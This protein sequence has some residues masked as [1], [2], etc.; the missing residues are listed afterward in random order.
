MKK[1]LALLLAFAVMLGCAACGG[2][3]ESDKGQNAD[4]NTPEVKK[5]GVVIYNFD[6]NFMTLY[7]KELERYFE[8]LGTDERCYEVTVMDGK[9]DQMAQNKAIEGF[10]AQG[11]D[12]IIL[13]AVKTS[14]LEPIVER[15]VSAGIPLVL[16]NRE[17]LGDNGDESCRF[18]LDNPLVCYVGA[19]S[20]QSGT[21][22]GEIIRDLPDRGDLNHD[23]KVSCIMLEG[24]PENPDAQY[25]TE[26]SVK[27]LRDA[28][29]EVELLDDRV[30]D[31]MEEKGQYYTALALARFGDR[32]EVVFSNNDAMALGAYTSIVG[33]G[34]TVGS[35]IYLVGVDALDECVMMV[36]DG[37]MTGTVRNDYVNQSHKAANVAIA[38]INGESI[39]NYYWVDYV[40]ITN[41]LG[42]QQGLE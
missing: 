22:Q 38:A 10:I 5:I 35:D 11:V 32:I 21:F 7:R 42:K 34:R 20:R 9:N 19:D 26:Y 24:D 6:D 30:G 2:R 3:G 13:N 33:A 39:E 37:R 1:A 28:E 27:A 36:R 17:P 41:D 18:I 31:W 25:R 16:I 8:S 23:G 40:K 15:V 29:I 12:A 4:A 14:S